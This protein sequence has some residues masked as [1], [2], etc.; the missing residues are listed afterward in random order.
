MTG[1]VIAWIA[2]SIIATPLILAL[3]AINEREDDEDH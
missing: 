2:L 1:F 3:F